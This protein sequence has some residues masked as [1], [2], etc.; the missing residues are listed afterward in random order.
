MAKQ[1]KNH[2]SVLIRTGRI[3]V[4]DDTHIS[5]GTDRKQEILK[6]LDE[7]QI[8]LLLISPSF[9]ASDYSYTV[10]LRRAIER[11]ER[12]E[13]RVIPVILRPIDWNIPP[14]DK[15]QGLPDQAKPVSR[16]SDRD[17]AFKNVADGIRKVVEQWEAHNLPEPVEERRSMIANLDRLIETVK[18]QMQPPPRAIATANTLQQLS[19]YI[20]NDVTL[21]DLVVGWQMLAQGAKQGEAPDIA[22]RRV[23]C[24]ELAIMASQFANEQGNMAQA[25]KTWEQWAKAFEHS[26]DPRQNAMAKTFAREL[27]ELKEAIS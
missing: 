6:R 10:Q 5:P 9:M 3:E 22:Q 4:W 27:A 7:D 23:T 15:L 12:K 1:L 26:N 13:A 8:I 18:S 25:S 11:H 16:W 14:L 24:N 19:I 17:E 2:L 21:A 20:P